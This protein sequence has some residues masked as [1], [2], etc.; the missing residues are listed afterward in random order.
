MSKS[1]KELARLKA[2]I[3]KFAVE[4]KY[5]APRCLSDQTLLYIRYIC[6]TLNNQTRYWYDQ[7]VGHNVP[8]QGE[9]ETMVEV[10]DYATDL[11]KQ[12]RGSEYI[13]SNSSPRSAAASIVYIACVIKG[14]NVTQKEVAETIDTNEST[15]RK[16]YNI[17]KKELKL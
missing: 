2:V 13:S 8:V 7:S 14:A 11:M 1:K 17:I 3:D 5:E 6:H 12:L 15:I 16:H 10:Q 4:N 9:T